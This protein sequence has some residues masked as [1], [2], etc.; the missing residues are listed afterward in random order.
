MAQLEEAS[1]LAFVDNANIEHLAVKE[2]D[3]D[4]SKAGV[5]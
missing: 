4:C 3:F 2:M 5:D 1:A